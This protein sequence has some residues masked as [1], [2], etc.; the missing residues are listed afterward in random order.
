[1]APTTYRLMTVNKVPER[2]KRL[3][4]RVTEILNKDQDYNIEHV[5]NCESKTASGPSPALLWTQ[6]DVFRPVAI[7]EV[8]PKASE[9]KPDIVVSRPSSFPSNSS[10]S[11]SCTH[12]GFCHN[13]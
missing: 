10:R 6:P 13:L 11:L 2:A 3:V 7:A 5:T 9:Y 1:M 12:A 4:G 8:E